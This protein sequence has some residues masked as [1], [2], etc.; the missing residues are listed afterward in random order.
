MFGRSV[1]GNPDNIC[2]G[3]M[4]FGMMHRKEFVNLI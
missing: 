3:N 1:N 2:C 4:D